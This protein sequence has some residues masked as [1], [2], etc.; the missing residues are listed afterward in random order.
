MKRFP[1]IFI[2]VVSFCICIFPLYGC[3]SMMYGISYGIV[4]K[5]VIGSMLNESG[6][7]MKEIDKQVNQLWT[8]QYECI[9]NRS[10]N[11]LV[12]PSVS[13]YSQQDVFNAILNIQQTINMID[14]SNDISEKATMYFPESNLVI[15]TD[16]GVGKLPPEE[17]KLL[18]EELL[19]ASSSYSRLNYNG[20]EAYI[21]TTIDETAG[22]LKKRTPNVAIKSSISNKKILNKILESRD[23]TRQ[24]SWVILQ[25]QSTGKIFASNIDKKQEAEISS[26]LEQRPEEENGY[27][28]A[29][30][31]SGKKV[32]T[33]SYSAGLDMVL[34]EIIPEKIIFSD[35]FMI[36]N[37]SFLS[38]ILL[39]LVGLIFYGMSS[40]L[41]N[42]PV[43][44]LIDSFARV[45]SHDFRVINHRKPL[46]KEYAM[47]YSSFNET[48]LYLDELV[49]KNYINRI[50]VQEAELKQLQFQINPHFLY[51]S[52]FILNSMVR[53]EDWENVDRMSDLLGTYLKYITYDKQNVVPLSAEVEHA[54]IYTD[55]QLFR[56]SR[57]IT[58]DFMNLPD[59]IGQ[60]MVPRILLQ[61]LIENSFLHGVNQTTSGGHIKI[62]FVENQNNIQLVVEDNGCGMTKEKIEE[63]NTH[64]RGENLNFESESVALVNIHKRL[65]T[66]FGKESG[67]YVEISQLGGLKIKAVI[68]VKEQ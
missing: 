57:R 34:Y 25:N 4:E 53:M 56:F 24:D 22:F 58:V 19:N 55:I 39:I 15:S 42:T 13:T 47:L 30:M 62:S 32:I 21:I 68:T 20:T 1:F 61:P 46:V 59:S 16:G 43:K 7:L 9:F 31:E 3:F 38:I 49:E 63:I 18:E 45:R 33:Y 29:N 41:F 28:I 37:L 27:W 14:S 67:L 17:L 40:R 44:V 60:L 64:I 48:A 8:R 66:L 6:V 2:L 11:T 10:V 52:F 51:N 12:F 65:L 5:K 26:V 35:L 36:R 54:K 23:P 50:L